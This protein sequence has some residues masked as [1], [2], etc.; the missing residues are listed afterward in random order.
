MQKASYDIV[1]FL[2]VVAVLILFLVGF[3]IFMTFLYRKK[4]Q[5]FEKNIE[6]LKLDNEKAVLNAQLEIQEQTLQH[7]SREIH[8]NISLSL[9]LAKL[10]LNT[11]DWNDRLGAEQKLDQSIELLT[12][13]IAELSHLSKGMNTELINQQGLLKAVEDEVERIK[14]AGLF[15]IQYQLTGETKYTGAREDLIIFRIIQEAFNNIIKHAGAKHTNLHIHYNDTKIIIT[16]SDDGSGFDTEL[17]NTGSKAGLKN[18]EGRIKM[19]GGQ[20]KIESHPGQGTTL[21]FTIPY[22][23]P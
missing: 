18:M 8:D 20:M 16:I 21:T 15:T 14:N 11:F 4:Q 9:T 6:Q 19:L 13:S 23:K 22:E 3:I 17:Y 2:V 7:I 5:T 12:N 10:Q 1:I